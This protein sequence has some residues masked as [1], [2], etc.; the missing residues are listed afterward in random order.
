MSKT[1]IKRH[2]IITLLLATVVYG[3]AAPFLAYEAHV[4]ATGATH[5]K[6]VGEIPKTEPY[7]SFFKQV[8]SAGTRGGLTI[9]ASNKEIGSLSMEL[10]KYDQIMRFS[11]IIS[12]KDEKYIVDLTQN[13]KKHA[14][15][16]ELIKAAIVIFANI[17][18]VA[19][20]DPEK[21]LIL[22]ESETLTLNAWGKKYWN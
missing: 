15:K 11:F 22:I 2:I 18:K 9:I 5:L 4:I 12:E 19:D 17:Q 14:L 8:S 20:S 3:C 1:S 7:D 10:I 16:D 6:A 21:M 13:Y